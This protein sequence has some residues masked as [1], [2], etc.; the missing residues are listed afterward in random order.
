MIPE[1]LRKFLDKNNIKYS[2]IKHQKAFTAQE[3]AES[4]HY[5]S[6]KLAK[7]VVI[8]LGDKYILAVIP[9]NKKIDLDA[10]RHLVHSSSIRLA[11]ESEFKRLFSD[12]EVGAM[13]PFGNLYG[14]DVYVEDSLGKTPEI[15]F[16][17]GTHSE[18]IKMKYND[19]ENLVHP[20]HGKFIQ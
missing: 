4:A 17:A 7:S 12:C 5:S 14:I 11:N 9:G 18:M 3:I 13:S 1:K 10:L 19:F 2:T 20:H 8:N 6:N 16:N 15:G